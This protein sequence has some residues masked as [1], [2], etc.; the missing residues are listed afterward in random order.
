[1]PVAEELARRPLPLAVLLDDHLERAQQLVAVLAAAVLERAEHAVAE[2]AQRLVVL[3]R[4]QQLERAEVAIGRDVLA[5]IP[6]RWRERRR[7]ECAAGLVEAAAK[8]GRR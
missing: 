5:R 1:M 3:Q 6:V 4:Q 8:R 2:E 7:L